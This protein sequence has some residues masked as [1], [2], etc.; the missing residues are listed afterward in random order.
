MSAPS[1]TA[2][3]ADEEDPLALAQKAATTGVCEEPRDAVQLRAA[4]L[5]TGV[6]VG[7][8]S[9]SQSPPVSLLLCSQITQH[10][11]DGAPHSKTLSPLAERK[12]P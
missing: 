6:G 12:H 11:S 10:C 7:A 3:L 1:A 2:D 8:G 5:F 9:P 4:Q